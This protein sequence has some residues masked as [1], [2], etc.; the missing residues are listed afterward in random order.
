MTKYLVSAVDKEGVNVPIFIVS[1][2]DYAETLYFSWVEEHREEDCWLSGYVIENIPE[3]AEGE[4]YSCEEE[5]E[6]YWYEYPA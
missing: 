4:K 1:S 2:S 3:F 5:K 6:H